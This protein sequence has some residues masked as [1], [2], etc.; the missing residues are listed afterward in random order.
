MSFDGESGHWY[1]RDGDP[2]YMTNGRGTTLRDARKLLLVPSVT[3]VMNVVAKPALTNWL[4]DQGIMAA[5]TMPRIDGEAEAAYIARIKLDSRAQAKAAAEE[6]SR[7]HDA[8]ECYFDNRQ[9][10][11]KYHEHVQAAR[12]EIERLYPGVTDWIAEKSFAH[13]LGFGGKVDLHSPST[14]IVHDWKTKDGDFSDGKKLAYDQ[15][16]QLAAYQVGLGLVGGKDGADDL[17]GHKQCGNSFVSRTH[18][19]AISS[20]VWTPEQIAKGWR[21]FELALALCKETSGYDGAF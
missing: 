12:R 4:V 15:N 19:G 7:I 5:L 21:I 14:G 1:T 18:P 9:Y 3:T 16:V 17:S 6:G 11:A 10:P 13:P 8:I 2:A 20:V